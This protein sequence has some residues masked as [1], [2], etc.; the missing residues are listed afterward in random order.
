MKYLKYLVLSLVFVL[1][2]CTQQNPNQYNHSTGAAPKNDAIEGEMTVMGDRSVIETT[3]TA[4]GARV[5]VETFNKGLNLHAV[6][7]S[8]ATYSE[9]ASKLG[10]KVEMME[11]NSRVRIQAVEQK[12]EW[13]EDRFF[14]YQ[15][16]M[17]N[18]GQSAPWGLPGKY[19]A[20]VKVLQALKEFEGKLQE[21]TIV[22]VIDTGV[23]YSHEDLNKNMWV[24]QKEAG[25]SNGIAGQDDD[26]NGFCDDVHGY[27]FTSGGRLK[28]HCGK[29]GDPDPNDEAG[30]GSHCAGVIAAVHNN[31]KGIAGMNPKAKIMALRALTQTGGSKRDIE[32]AISYAMENGANVISASYG[33]SG[34]SEITKKLIEAAG[35]KGILFVA[36]AGND[37]QNME[38]ENNRKYPAAYQLPNLLTVAASDNMDNPAAFTNYGHNYTDVFAPGVGIVSLYKNGGYTIMDGTSMAAPLVSGLASLLMSA[39]PALKNDPVRVKEIIMATVDTNASMYGKVA[40]NGRV[41]ALKALQSAGNAVTVSPLAWQEEAQSIQ[42]TGHNT[43]LVDIKHKIEKPGA[44]AIR[45]HFDFIEIDRQFDSIYIYDKNWKLVTE[46]TNGSARD[47]WSPVVSG[48]TA[49]VRFVNAKVKKNSSPVQVQMSNSKVNECL[50]KGGMNAGPVI[51]DDPSQPITQFVCLQDNLD[52]KYEDLQKDIDETDVFFSWQSEGFTI[53][54]I[55][56]TESAI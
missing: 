19:D 29:I 40:S 20:D 31:Q 9:V 42:Q 12:V 36:A 45:V 5:S 3:L 27:D 52:Y 32:R 34:D 17:N 15:W 13:P 2:A 51:S 35:K 55:Q 50:D 53:D 46:L 30:H 44:K 49:Y 1:A 4:M 43:E 47:V 16:A 18:I 8:G 6:N 33:G 54:K 23:D 28:P 21:D 7:F 25:K 38:I 24:N 41:N 14:F 39:Y 22:A 26:G 37:G 56:F 48:D 10:P 11:Q